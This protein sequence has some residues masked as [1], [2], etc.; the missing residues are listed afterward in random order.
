MKRNLV[1]SF[2]LVA[3]ATNEVVRRRLTLVTAAFLPV[4]AILLL[5]V[6]IA[7]IAPPPIVRFLLGL[8]ALPLYAVFA[9]IVH[10]VV[11]L[12]DHALPSR[13]GIFWTERET[14]F[15]GCSLESGSSIS[16]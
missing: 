14:R 15:L 13:W 9:T 10:R 12:G 6:V 2:A 11:L 8:I 5:D 16:R 4:T 3:E 1:A 7:E